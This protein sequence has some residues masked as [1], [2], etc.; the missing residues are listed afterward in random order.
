MRIGELAQRTGVEVDTIRYYEKAELLP[1]PPRQGNGYREYGE[2][3]IERLSFIRHCRALDMPLTDVKRLLDFVAHPEVDCGDINRLIDHQLERVRKR[4]YSMQMLERQLASLR[5]QC[6]ENSTARE[7][8]ILHELV[9][10][11]RDE[12]CAK[13]LTTLASASI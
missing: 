3:H 11:S 9:V 13:S 2:R 1:S 10:A 8:G 5:A 4:L 12:G 7:C 6:D